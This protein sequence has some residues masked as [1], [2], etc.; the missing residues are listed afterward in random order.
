MPGDRTK[1]NIEALRQLLGSMRERLGER[2]EFRALAQLDK[3]ERTGLSMPSADGLMLRGRLVRQLAETS[4]LWRAYVH[5]EAAIAELEGQEHQ[6]PG[7]I[8]AKP[9]DDARPGKALMEGIGQPTPLPASAAPGEDRAAVARVPAA[10]PPA[11]ASGTRAVLD[12][13]RPVSMI[14]NQATVAG[15]NARQSADAGQWQ[16][17]QSDSLPPAIDLPAAK[18]AALPLGEARYALTGCTGA[19]E[20]GA[21]SSRPER[22]DAKAPEAAGVLRRGQSGSGIAPRTERLV[23]AGTK[24][25]QQTRLDAVEAE[26]ERLIDEDFAIT[27]PGYVSP[28]PDPPREVQLQSLEP[29]FL[30]DIGAEVEEAEVTIVTLGVLDDDAS[31]DPARNRH[32]QGVPEA[33]AGAPGMGS[34]EKNAATAAPRRAAPRPPA[35]QEHDD[36]MP[37]NPLAVEEAAVEIVIRGANELPSTE[38]NPP[39]KRR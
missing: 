19:G 17:R 35:V 30:E 18:S 12:R 27:R 38:T 28:V 20:P 11:A 21:V 9:V 5:V 25:T 2:E 22:R 6:E 39:A 8:S 16:R 13:I 26:L 3:R 32:G 23:E 24:P 37:A 4:R 15:A 10:P 34:S 31:G 14:A 7:L 29:D 33:S 1:Q 36:E